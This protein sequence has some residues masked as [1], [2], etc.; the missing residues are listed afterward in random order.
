M[1]TAYRRAYDP[2][3]IAN[4]ETSDRSKVVDRLTPISSAV[5]PQSQKLLAPSRLAQ[6]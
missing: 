5:R 6:P 2:K 4:K 3:E 1:K